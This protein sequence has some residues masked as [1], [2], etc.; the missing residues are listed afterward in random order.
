MFSNMISIAEGL[1]SSEDWKREFDELCRTYDVPGAQVGL[2]ALGP[3]G[4]LDLRTAESG[5]TSRATGVDVTRDTLFQI[6]SI[7]KVWTTT[8]VMQLVDEG[9]VELDTPVVEVLPDFT[10]ADPELARAVTVRQLL[11]HTSGIDGDLFIDTGDGDDC[12]TR[13]V[14]ELSTARSVTRPGGHLS[15]CNAGFVVAGRIVEVLRGQVW[16]DVVADRLITP[17]GLRHTITRAKD[18]PLFRTAVGHLRS[19][20]DG[21]DLRPTTQWMLPR[22]QGPAGLVC[23]SAE[24][25]LLFAAAHLRDGL[26]VDGTRVLSAAAARLMRT[27]QVDLHAD[28]STIDGWGLGW[29]LARWGEDLAAA[30]GGATIGQIADLQIFPEHQ[31]ALVV[32]TNSRGGSGL[33]PALYD[34]LGPTMGLTP[35]GP[36]VDPADDGDLA[37]LTGTWSSTESRWTIT[38]TRE[39]TMLRMTSNS[40]IT[41]EPDTPPQR[42]RASGPGRFL[43]GIDGAD[44]EVSHGRSDGQEYLYYGRLLR[45]SVG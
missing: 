36:T 2:L 39:G 12:L 29:S 3:D 19:D 35:P 21:P 18:A 38:S 45:R 32:L 41:G 9:L 5:V 30:H 10:L 37:D 6:G 28:S 42:I 8:L 22:S 31:L 7:T 13:F 1:V 40:G 14:A 15:Y 11:D 16:D 27:L 25:L 33:I 44:I 43:V 26:G 34:R 20:S 4:R 23:A 24:D 17:L